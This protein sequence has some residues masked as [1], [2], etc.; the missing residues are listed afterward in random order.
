YD[1]VDLHGGRVCGP[2]EG[3]GLR[4]VRI[5]QQAGEH[6][7][8]PG[9]RLEDDLHEVTAE[10]VVAGVAAVV[11]TDDVDIIG[12]RVAELRAGVAGLRG[13]ALD[14]QGDQDGDRGVRLGG[15]ERRH[16][17]G[18]RRGRSGHDRPRGGGESRG[19]RR[20]TRQ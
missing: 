4:A 13:P 7:A 12:P 10:D 18:G 16:R 1:V 20:P 6:Q 8:V 2:G 11:A 17:G 19:L 5:V 15:G 3:H 14:R 9:T